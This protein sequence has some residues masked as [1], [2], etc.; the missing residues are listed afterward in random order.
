MGSG[1]GL[2]P[3]VIQVVSFPQELRGAELTVE[4]GLNPFVIQVVS[5]KTSRGQF[6]Q[7][8]KSQSLRN[9][10]RFLRSGCAMRW[11]GSG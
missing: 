7:Q 4:E 9:S 8:V 11:S 3:F 2:N 1:L 5:F 6:P 10:G